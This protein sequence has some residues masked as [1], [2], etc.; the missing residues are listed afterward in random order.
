METPY[1]HTCEDIVM[2]STKCCLKKR[3]KEVEGN[4]N[5]LEGV[6]FFKVLCTCM[7]LS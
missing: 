1:M 4:G 3:G 7:E 2:K 5:I 6:K